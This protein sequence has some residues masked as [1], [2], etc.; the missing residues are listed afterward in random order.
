MKISCSKEAYILEEKFSK[1]S[2]SINTICSISKCH[3]EVEEEN[4]TTTTTKRPRKPKAVLKSATE[5]PCKY[6][7]GLAIGKSPEG[8]Y[9]RHLLDSKMTKCSFSRNCEA[10]FQ[11]I[12]SG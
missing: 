5:H 6:P 8:G 10:L 3:E 7:K 9:A 12:K 2:N 1:S 11:G 4:K